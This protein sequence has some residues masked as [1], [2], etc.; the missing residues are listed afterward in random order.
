MIFFAPDTEI[1]SLNGLSR[2]TRIIYDVTGNA[3]L[4]AKIETTKT[5]RDFSNQ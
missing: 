5:K 3:K 2:N 1:I 4:S